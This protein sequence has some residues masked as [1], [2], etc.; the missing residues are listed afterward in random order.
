MASSYPRAARLSFLRLGFVVLLATALLGLDAVESS[1][2]GTRGRRARLSDDLVQKLRIGDAETSAVIFT[3]S[4]ARVDSLAARH[5]L[6]IRKRL[7]SGALLEVPGYRL[8][9]MADDP[10][11]DAL[12][13][14]HRVSAQMATAVQSTGAD[15]VQAGLA[16][17]GVRGLTG[18]GVGI[19][20]IDSGIAFVPE[21]RGRIV[22]SRDFTD[23]RGLGQTPHLIFFR[24]PQNL[25]RPS[26]ARSLFL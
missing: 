10:E 19:A 12:S 6:R 23:G 25:H 21:L 20:V 3:G 13:G 17:A 9:A 4:Q 22:A 5:G 2:Q 14:N 26:A 1:A 11:V 15:L 16:P 24:S 18:A 7:K 8:Q